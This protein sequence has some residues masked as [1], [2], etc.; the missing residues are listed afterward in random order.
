[1]QTAFPLGKSPED[2]E[3]VTIQGLPSGLSYEVAE[4]AESSAGYTVT[5]SGLTGTIP[6]GSTAEAEVTNHRS[7]NPGG[8]DDTVDITGTKTWVDQSNAGGTRPADLEL[9]LYRSVAGGE[10]VEVSAEVHWTKSGNRWT[11]EFRNLPERDGSGRLY[12]Y[13]VVE[14]V[15][16]GYVGEADGFNFTNTLADPER[17]DLTG[18]KTW[19]GDT[20]ENRPESITVVLYDGNGQVVRRVTVTAEDGWR[21]HFTNLPKI[22]RQRQ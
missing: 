16:D 18:Q 22:R 10:R 7:S 4:T 2:G 17:I 21:Y 1:M 19:V 9:T 8:G 12:T 6:S 11:Y 20:A 3:N 14:T 13:E 5:S 15:P